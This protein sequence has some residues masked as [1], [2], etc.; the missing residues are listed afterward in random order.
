MNQDESEITRVADRTEMI[1]PFVTQANGPRLSCGARGLQ[2]GRDVSCRGRRQHPGTR[3]CVDDP[4]QRRRSSRKHALLVQKGGSVHIEDL[5]SANGTLVNGVQIDREALHD[6][7][8]IRLGSTT[9]LKFTYNDHLDETF[10]RQMYEAALR[11]GLTKAF[12][13]QYFLDRL[14]TEVAYARRH[15]SALAL[16]IFDVDHFKR[17]NDTY[18]RRRR[19]CSACPALSRVQ[20]NRACRR[21]SRAVWRGRVC[22]DLSRRYTQRRCRSWRTSSRDGGRHAVR[23]G[24]S[25]LPVTVDAVG[26]AAM[27]DA[28]IQSGRT[29]H[30]CGYG[31][32]PGKAFRAQPSGLEAAVAWLCQ[33]LALRRH[34]AK[35]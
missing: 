31:A 5:Q 16:L 25:N 1:P 24:R 28:A 14:E 11:D 9:I 2:R 19:G 35:C 18:G 30:R 20:R 26:V 13:R 8:K 15:Q 7:D 12:N 10:Q 21:R 6:G 27:P 17:V 32:L 29:R 3:H 22:R 4:A 34:R 23:G 33:A